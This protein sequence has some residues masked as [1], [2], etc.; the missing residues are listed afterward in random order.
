MSSRKRTSSSSDSRDSPKKKNNRIRCVACG[1]KI[2]K[3]DLLL[4]LMPR[5]QIT[6]I[7]QIKNNIFYTDN[8][9]KFIW[10][11]RDWNLSKVGCYGCI[12]HESCWDELRKTLNI[13][14]TFED[15]YK[16]VNNK[17]Q[18]SRITYLD[19]LEDTW[20]NFILYKNASLKR[21]QNL[22]R[23]QKIRCARSYSIEQ[24]VNRR[25]KIMI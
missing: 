6:G 23:F 21:R 2:R 17:N 12:T 24:S 22:D 25:K 8:D 4:G 9:I 19:S 14:V 7:K 1:H 5:G 15:I 11:K 10:N 13:Q 3:Q 16:H 18:L 20:K